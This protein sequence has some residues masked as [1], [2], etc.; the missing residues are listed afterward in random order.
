MN[1]NL[2]INTLVFSAV[3]LSF[4]SAPRVKIPDSAE[5]GKEYIG[6]KEEEVTNKTAELTLNSLKKAYPE[7][8]TVLRDAHPKHHGC[9]MAKFEVDGNIPPELK[10]GL[11]SKPAS[12]SSWIRYSNGATTPKADIEG[13]IR[14]M[15]IKLMGVDG[16][17]LLPDEKN[18]KT[19][20]F[21][22]I[23]HP[24]LP[25]GDPAEYLALF[26]AAFKGSPGSYIF[27]WNP[28]NWKLGALSKVKAIRSKKIPSMLSIR[29]WSTTPYKLGNTAVK[30]SAK[31]CANTDAKVP[32]NPNP[33]YLKEVMAAELSKKEACFEFMVQTQK[34]AVKMP[35]EDPAEEW[36]ESV[37][38]FIKVAT[39]RIP[40][41]SFDTKE[42]MNFCENLSFTPWHSLPD[43]KPLGGINRVRKKVYEDISRYRH[44]KNGVPRKEPVK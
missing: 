9:V 25:V 12:Y 41:Q 4:C 36:D 6:E 31:P 19:Q 10:Q 23:N 34:D 37:S 3:L 22:L 1:R 35:V 40:V 14:G 39:I 16:E 33:D 29:Y 26:E 30:Y 15:A 2:K 42:Q 17:K 32:E 44:E 18:E 8:K 7:G 21:L 13:D 11:F 24:V 43:H 5:I 38:P 27:G 20:D 28:F